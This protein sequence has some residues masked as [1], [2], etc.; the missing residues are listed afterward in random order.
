[1]SY[2]DDDSEGQCECGEAAL[3]M[4]Y[5]CRACLD[6]DREAERLRREERDDAEAERLATA[7]L[8]D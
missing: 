1:M 5:S 4:R 8:N 3:P 2:D 7:R 6:A